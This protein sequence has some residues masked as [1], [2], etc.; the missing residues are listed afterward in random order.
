MANK[1]WKRLERDVAK[2]LTDITGVSITRNSCRENADNSE[3]NSDVDAKH[4]CLAYSDRDGV[5][6]ECKYRSNSFGSLYKIYKQYKDSGDRLIIINTKFLLFDPKLILKMLVWMYD[7]T[8][9]S[10]TEKMAEY[11]VIHHWTEVDY[12]GIMVDLM[13]A[14]RYGESKNLL[15]LLAIR[16]KREGILGVARM[17]E[18]IRVKSY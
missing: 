13:Q 4:P 10:I 3:R 2:I 15:P 8:K 1:N 11:S 9:H 7:D 18:L 17:S 16:K 14:A 12:T 6:F 5:T